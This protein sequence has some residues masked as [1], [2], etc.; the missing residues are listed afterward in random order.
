MIFKVRNQLV[1]IVLFLFSCINLLAQS[2]LQNIYGKIQDSESHATLIG[3][4]VVVLNSS[5]LIGTT[6]D[7]DGHYELKN[8]P[9]GRV[10]LQISFMGYETKVV[11]GILLSSGKA[12]NIDILLKE[13]FN[14]VEEV[15]VTAKRK[16]TSTLKV[17][18]EMATVSAM[19]YN[20]EQSSRY[21]GS[22]N[23]PSRLVL[24]FAGV[25]NQGD[26]QN[27][28]SIRGNTPSALLW[29]IDGLEVQS[30][31]HFAR[32]GALGAINMVSS[33][34]LES[35]DFYTA[36]FPAQYG[37]AGSGVFDLSMRKG[38]TN[39]YEF[40]LSAGFMG[41]EAS[42][43]GPF[44]KKYGGSFLVSYRYSTLAL[45]NKIGLNVTRNTNP[46][47]Q[48]INYKI[49]LPSKKFGEFQIYGLYGKGKISEYASDPT[50]GDWYDSYALNLIGIKNTK[51]IKEKTQLKSQILYS[52]SK[53]E[54]YNEWTEYDF[55]PDMVNL[56]NKT[57]LFPVD[58][59][60]VQLDVKSNTKINAK[61]SVQ[62]GANVAF[63]NYYQNFSREINQYSIA[64]TD[65]FGQE[66]KL[67][68]AEASLST[69]QIKAFMQHKLRITEKLSITPGVHF[70]HSNFNKF[71]S[72]EPRFGLEYV[73]KDIHK[74]TLGVGL[75]SRLEPLGYYGAEG[76]YVDDFDINKGEF[77][78][79]TGQPNKYLDAT[80]SVHFVVGN[81]WTLAPKL[82][83][84]VET[85]VQYLYKIPIIDE[86]IGYSYYASLNEL[87]PSI[88]DYNFITQQKYANKGKG[89]NYGVDVS[90][91]K[92]FAK[93]YYILVNGSYYQSK[94]KVTSWYWHRDK[95]WLNTKYNG[96][97][98]ATLTA[99]KD[100][101]VG[102]QKN[103]SISM[104]TRVI[105][106]G[107]NREY[108]YD[109]DT[110]YGKR[111]KNYFRWDARLAYIRNKKKYSWTLS[112]DIQ[113]MTNRI[114]ETTN[115]AIKGQGVLP[116][117]NYKVNF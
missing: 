100:F 87:Y 103:N 42:A 98:I 5:P 29:N 81:K 34:S 11:D 25:R 2:N 17:D 96:N 12:K 69:F 77:I 59:K 85:Y 21:A 66:N 62:I 101:T 37:N 86:D 95:K 16:N 49:H 61:H 47:Y 40:S 53:G 97:F 56:L 65:T 79:K 35:V 115:P 32:D 31:N 15:V 73:Y 1:F 24:S 75:H 57:D 89:L 39:E 10:D 48:D 71:F 102:K 107:N 41:L 18:N 112:A 93:N 117:L 108:D 94:Y 104:N 6:T 44:S 51:T 82:H 14:S 67:K 33:N 27:G 106:A 92:A 36:A 76:R 88:Y 3:A 60:R 68:N 84:Q 116:V 13:E 4:A 63:I 78:Y 58:E 46:V 43:E 52:E 70:I 64:G 99:G 55:S 111:L 22:L 110:P 28:I 91:E 72:V 90:L 45:F 50:V 80:R 83:L 114:N 8:V 19:S 38:N 9:V 30:P 105:W 20:L 54:F 7:L 26:I 23:D 109:T 74:F 113:N